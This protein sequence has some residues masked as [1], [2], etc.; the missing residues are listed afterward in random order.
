[1]LLAPFVLDMFFSSDDIPCDLQK[2]IIRE[3]PYWSRSHEA[4]LN[5]LDKMESR[6]RSLNFLRS[7]NQTLLR[8]YE[9]A[10]QWLSE[11]W[12]VDAHLIIFVRRAVLA[13]HS[14]VDTGLNLLSICASSAKQ[15]TLLVIAVAYYYT[16]VGHN[17]R[18]HCLL[19]SAKKNVSDLNY[20]LLCRAEDLF[21]SDGDV[22]YLLGKF[23]Y[24]PPFADE[25]A[26]SMDVGYSTLGTSETGFKVPAIPKVSVQIPRSALRHSFNRLS[27]VLPSS[28]ASCSQ[29][30]VMPEGKAS[31]RFENDFRGPR[32]YSTPPEAMA[33]F[34]SSHHQAREFPP[35]TQIADTLLGG[36]VVDSSNGL[37]I[38]PELSGSEF[39][40]T[41]RPVSPNAGDVQS[42]LL[43]CSDSHIAEARFLHPIRQPL[44]SVQLD[45]LPEASPLLATN[46]SQLHLYQDAAESQHH[47][48]D[49][50]FT[51]TVDSSGEHESLRV[52][53]C[54]PIIT[55]KPPRELPPSSNENLNRCMCING[56]LYWILDI[57]G[58]GGSS[59][60]Y[61][62]LDS[63]RNLWAIKDVLLD[64]ASADLV[65]SYLN[66]IVML[67]SL[68]DS[69]RVIRLHD[70]EHQASHLYLVLELASVDLKTV[71]IDLVELECQPR[72]S[73]LPGSL[74]T[75]YVAFYWVQM[76]R[77]VKVLHDRR[78]VHLDLK[79]QNF[80]LVRGNLKL[81]D[82]GISQRLPDDMTCV[83]PTLQL[84]TLTFM[85]P[86][87]LQPPSLSHIYS[88]ADE[89]RFS[90][91]RKS[92]IW[93]LGVMLYF[94]LYQR[95]PFPQPTA[96][97]RML[98]II[99]R[100][101]PIEFSPISN[102]GLYQ[103]L[104]RC[105]VRNFKER[106]SV[107]ELINISYG[108]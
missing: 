30:D 49:K 90:V 65:N 29:V 70:H 101:S 45:A 4:W 60:V 82:L 31:Y 36:V 39:F 37:L 35:T 7:A 32:R 38:N 100:N 51:M 94:M 33:S 104:Q 69:G 103:A 68:K 44:R 75:L 67:S 11:E 106:A 16:T 76:L 21:A 12:T 77:C 55:P 40:G 8:L 1:M 59:V 3:C 19:R 86:E 99:D 52:Q 93:S 26:S 20:A 56:S 27:E 102:P 58:R 5:Y 18:A 47:P 91:G 84:G 10:C 89:T 57:I 85:S 107:D 28:R 22:K 42:K 34:Y 98:A 50:H 2:M 62:A 71:L 95:S 53:L 73:D 63:N 74:P 6:L 15:N 105:L 41:D 96:Q 9:G 108:P 54:S 43:P 13:L 88:D 64:G 97:S 17:A 87:R 81:I 23:Y 83:N 25:S 80:V 66:E 72:C 92:D 79:P 48:T 78:I 61:S 46:K 14:D 24:E